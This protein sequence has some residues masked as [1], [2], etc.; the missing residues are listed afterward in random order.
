MDPLLLLQPYCRYNV[1]KYLIAATICV[2]DTI[3]LSI[4]A[5]CHCSLNCQPDNFHISL[6]TRL[7][8]CCPCSDLNSGLLGIFKYLLSVIMASSA[9]LIYANTQ[10]SP[11]F[12]STNHSVSPLSLSLSQKSQNIAL[13]SSSKYLRLETAWLIAII[14]DA[15]A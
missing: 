11:G 3:N 1:V 14:E 13:R 7:N 12:V 4:F 8:R 5:L 2:M 15:G 6:S 9:D 10:L